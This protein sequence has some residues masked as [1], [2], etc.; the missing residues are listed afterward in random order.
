MN[1]SIYEEIGQIVEKI[2]VES[3]KKDE[4]YK[5]TIEKV[6]EKLDKVDISSLI[7]DKVR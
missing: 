2:D 1:E 3:Q 4:K 5:K 7:E 6:I